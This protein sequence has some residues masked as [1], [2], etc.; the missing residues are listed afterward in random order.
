MFTYK[1]NSKGHDSSL[2]LL[3]AGMDA[4]QSAIVTS[5]LNKTTQY[6]GILLATMAER[7]L[8][9]SGVKLT[10]RSFLDPCSRIYFILGACKR[11]KLKLTINNVPIRRTG[12]VCSP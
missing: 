8:N 2:S 7:L 1:T 4:T 12:V 5:H 10:E 11:L 3:P 6:S 9:D